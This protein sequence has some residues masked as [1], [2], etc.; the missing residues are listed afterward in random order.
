M[1]IIESVVPFCTIIHK[2]E[3]SSSSSK[4]YDG[5]KMP[6]E[7]LAMV[8]KVG[9]IVENLSHKDRNKLHSMLRKA[10]DTIFFCEYKNELCV[11]GMMR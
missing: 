7:E 4:R 9:D 5:S 1:P 2:L 6:V 11:F 8:V 3:M 10:N